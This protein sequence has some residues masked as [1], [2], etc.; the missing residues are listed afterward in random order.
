MTDDFLS[1]ITFLGSRIAPTLTDCSPK[2]RLL[3]RNDTSLETFLEISI[4]FGDGQKTKSQNLQNYSERLEI[5]T[6]Y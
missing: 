4:I 1:V 3:A 5:F 6:Y 2:D